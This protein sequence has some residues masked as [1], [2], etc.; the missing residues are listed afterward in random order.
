[1]HYD[2]V[3]V[4]KMLFGFVD[5]KFSDY[6]TIRASS[7]TRGHDCKLLL[8]YSRLTVRKHFFCERVVPTVYGII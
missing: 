3:F 8:N 7:T 4:Y 1:L 5:L 6:F 2:L